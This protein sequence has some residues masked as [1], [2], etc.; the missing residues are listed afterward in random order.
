MLQGT[1]FVQMGV[2]L[3][4][5]W[6]AQG[7]S[8]HQVSRG[9]YTLRC[10]GH[11]EYHRARAIATLQFNC[12]LALLV[13]V[14]V[15]LYSVVSGRNRGPLDSSARYM[16]LGAELQQFANPANFT[17]DSDDDDDDDVV[18]EIKDG[19]VAGR[20]KA[21]VVEHGMNGHGYRH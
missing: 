9:N 13:V 10:K 19:N 12:H 18:E 1:W 8:L 7:C 6:V 14:I 11:P 21:V 17:L 5:R 3:F 16:P 15:G 2:S 20:Q 4:S